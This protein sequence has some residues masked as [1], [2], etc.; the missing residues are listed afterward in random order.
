MSKFKPM[1]VSFDDKSFKEA[2]EKA[3]N[4]HLLRVEATEW[5]EGVL[6]V[7]NIDVQKLHEDMTQY[8]K[9]LVSEA[10]K[11][12]NQLELSASK[13]IEAKEIKIHELREI[14]SKYEA[15]D[16]PL[17]MVDEIPT[18]SVDK[19]EY[20]VW[21]RS[22]NMNNKLTKGNAFIFAL[23]Q[24]SGDINV[25]H[26]FITNATSGVIRYDLFKNEYLVSPEYIFN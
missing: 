1:L 15:I 8:F 18:F 14:Q 3:Q 25:Q 11:D 19:K 7:S 4:K 6:D 5:I 12:V 13:L 9:E 23:N 21:T 22:E 24:L 20:E 2:Q 16:L 26:R 10:Y 17:T